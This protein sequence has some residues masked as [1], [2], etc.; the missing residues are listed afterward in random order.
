MSSLFGSPIPQHR[1]FPVGIVHNFYIYDGIEELI[2]Y[3]DMITILDTATENDIVNIY[4][5]TPG[6]DVYTAISIIHAIMRTDA[7][8]ITHADGLVASAGTLIY[9]AAPTRAI[10]HYSTFMFHDASTGMS[11]KLNENTKYIQ[12]LTKLIERMAY[13]LYS[14]YFTED[15]ISEI[16]EGKDYY[17]DSDEMIA[18]L[19]AGEEVLKDMMEEV[20]ENAEKETV[21]R[22]QAPK[23]RAKKKVD[24]VE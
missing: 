7:N 9:F 10:N 18:R 23:K 20:R 3:T 24:L 1:A 13:E 2:E 14:P 4:L 19:Q 6:G 15:E 22:A 5:N 17:C 11:G 21:E 16:L 8:V 12:S